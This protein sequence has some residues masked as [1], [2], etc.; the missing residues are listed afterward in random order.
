M[1]RATSAVTYTDLEQ[2]GVLK[3]QRHEILQAFY[4]FGQG[5]AAEVLKK[6]GLDGNRNLA[7][8]RI[9]ELVNAGRLVECGSRPCTV[10]GKPAIVWGPIARNA[11]PVPLPVLRVVKFTE[12]ECQLA[13]DIASGK[14]SGYSSA[15]Q[16]LLLKIAS[17][18]D[19]KVPS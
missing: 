15:A 7:R 5:T 18:N 17:A 3:G 6:A 1:N 12:D 8:A 4:R 11:T 2:K 16:A 13:A 19:S 9:S 14:V 10:T